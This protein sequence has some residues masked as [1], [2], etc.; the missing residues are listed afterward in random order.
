MNEEQTI[1]YI[2]LTLM[3]DLGSISRNR[4]IR[5]CG[6][7]ENCFFLQFEELLCR[8]AN[9]TKKSRIG[10]KKIGSF[11]RSR[12]EAEY[13]IRA[14]EIYRSCEKKNIA[15]I[16]RCDVRYPHKFLDTEDM[17]V[18]IYTAGTLR[19]ND[20]SDTVGIVGA[21]RCTPEG[22][23]KAIRFAQFAVEK[24][25]PVIS[26]MAK[27][28]DSYSH[29]AALKSNGY[30][31]AVLGSGPDICYPR[32]QQ[33]LYEE[34]ILHGTVLSEYPPGTSP[35]QYMF[36]QR[37]RLIAGLSDELYVIDAGKHSGTESTVEYSKMYTRKV[38]FYG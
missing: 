10:E 3:P 1:L 6:N 9:Q 36:P 16:P 15:V 20:F 29:T 14:E 34:I 27:G 21:R 17:P 30:T 26:G 13:R 4:L 28:I 22:K 38:H 25:I 2:M 37:N 24:G 31:V 7:I 11:I 8:D 19:I 5:L 23:E 32:E 18:V 12:N 33:R 35:H